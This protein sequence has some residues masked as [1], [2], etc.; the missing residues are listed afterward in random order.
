[1]SS[2]PKA[3]L[4]FVNTSNYA[5]IGWVEK[6]AANSRV[7]YDQTSMFGNPVASKF[8]DRKVDVKAGFLENKAGRAR[9]RHGVC[10]P[11]SMSPPEISP[12]R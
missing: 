12:G 11:Q 1:M 8:W 7:P 10:S 6:K 9:N 4:V 3:G 2:D 5:S